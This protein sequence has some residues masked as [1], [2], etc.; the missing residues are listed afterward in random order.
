MTI[1]DFQLSLQS[2]HCNI[3][4]PTC[5]K[6]TSVWVENKTTT[7]IKGTDFGWQRDCNHIL[8]VC[9]HQT[10]TSS[11]SGSDLVIMAQTHRHHHPQILLYMKTDKPIVLWLPYGKFPKILHTTVSDKVAYA[12][13]ADPDQTAPKREQSDLGPHCLPFHKVF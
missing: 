11:P 3:T 10:C 1:V 2:L 7:N 4:A 9:L 8:P 12:K 5:V 6:R 13:S